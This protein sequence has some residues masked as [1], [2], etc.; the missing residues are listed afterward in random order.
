LAKEIRYTG[1]EFGDAAVVPHT[2]AETLKQ[3]YGD[4]KDKSTLLVAM[5]RS[6]DIPAYVALLNVGR[7]EDV[8]KDLPGMGRFDHAI[9]FV[10]GSPDLWIDATDEYARVGQLPASDQGRLALI[11]RPETDSPVLTAVPASK[12][13][14][15][16]EER[17]FVLSEN[18]P[19]RVI[20]TNRPLG[21]I[22]SEFR[23]YYANQEEKDFKK[24]L[25]DYVKNQYLSDKLDRAVHSDPADLTKP[26]DLVVEASKAKRGFTE[27]DNAV[28][29]IRIDSIFQRLP[30]DLLEKPDDEE[31]STDSNKD[32]P[33]KP[34]T[35]DY[36][37]SEPFVTEWAL[38]CSA[39]AWFPPQASSRKRRNSRWPRSA[40]RKFLHCGGWRSF[41]CPAV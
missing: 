24:G 2:P 21:T 32:K 20:E 6:A 22:E 17:R 3:K 26:F 16:L 41:R 12:D 23:S 18:G 10:P 8:V 9:V 36:Q 1:V 35:A 34:R 40:D 13:N 27:L 30:N 19:A 15:A 4:C 11:A 28:V 33:K 38:H 31:K 29:A 25:T 14:V 37:L 5:L 7:R 39:A